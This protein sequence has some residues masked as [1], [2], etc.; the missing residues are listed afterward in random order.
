MIFQQLRNEEAGCLSYVVG[1]GMAGTAAVVDPGRDF[2][3][4]YIAFARRKGLRITHIFDTHSH[5]DHVSGNRE[6]A[7][8]TGASVYLSAAAGALFEHVPVK[9]GEEFTLGNVTL[10]VLDTPGHTPDSICLLVTDHA[11]GPEPWLLFTGDALFIGDVGRTDFGGEAGPAQFYES[12]FGKVLTLDDTV[13]IY[14]AHCS[15]SLCGRAMSAKGGSTLGFERRFNPA[16]QLRTKEEFIRFMTAGVPPQPP[17]FQTIVAKNR[18]LLPIAEAKPCPYTAEETHEAL[19]RGAWLVDVRDPGTFGEG[20]IPGALNVW[21]ESPQF[22]DRVG[23]FVPR[24]T[25]VILVGQGPSDIERTVQAL[26][27]VG[28]DEILG[29]LKWGMAEWRSASLPVETVSQVTVHELATFREKRPELVI[30]DVREFFEW[31]EGYIEGA[32]HLPMLDAMRRFGELPPE[33]PKAAICSLGLRS[34]T[35]IS[36]LKQRGLQGWYNVSGGMT[37]WQK[38]GLPTVKPSS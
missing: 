16:L 22:A 18:G 15:G 7:A 13:E 20:H 1:C 33:H 21:I 19:A 26:A 29:F 32:R 25:P 35:V 17:N 38:A 27:R 34:S 4:D 2:V 31:L 37:A 6:L 30:I 9:D 28:L 24:G 36:A 23:W 3:D 5:A 8:K 11:R 12:L 14:P 10:K